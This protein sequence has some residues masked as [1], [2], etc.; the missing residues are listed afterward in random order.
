MRTESNHIVAI[1]NQN[2]NWNVMYPI[3]NCNKSCNVDKTNTKAMQNLENSLGRHM[4]HLR[5]WAVD[6]EPAIVAQQQRQSKRYR[7]QQG[8]LRFPSKAPL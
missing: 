7:P 1:H 6:P 4:T 2:S 3:N 8:Q 5:L